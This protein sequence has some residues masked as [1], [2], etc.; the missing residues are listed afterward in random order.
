M[1][2]LWNP[3]LDRFKAASTCLQSARV[4]MG[5][6]VSF[7]NSLIT[8]VEECREDFDIYEEGKAVSGQDEYDQAT[9]RKKEK[10]TLF[11][12]KHEDQPILSTRE[13]FLIN[14]FFVIIDGL[15]SE[16]KRRAAAY[17]SFFDYFFFV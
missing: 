1:V 3:I 12:E 16:I 17:R 7:Y 4:D 5:S 9:S 13:E 8:F 11:G 14:F 6:V 10:K 2:A 15:K